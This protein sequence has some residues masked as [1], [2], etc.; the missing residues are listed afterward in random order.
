[1]SNCLNDSWKKGD[2]VELTKLNNGMEPGIYTVARGGTKKPGYNLT[3]FISGAAGSTKTIYTDYCK[4][5]IVTIE[6]FEEQVETLESE[7]TI[8]KA[9]VKWM[10]ANKVDE[11]D[12]T[13]FKI[14]NTMQIVKDEKDE[15]KAAKLIAELFKA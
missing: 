13:Q 5:A 7:I 10:K 14:W 11:Y 4:A 6:D 9:K 3:V 8:A 12:E 2:K 1:M 15:M